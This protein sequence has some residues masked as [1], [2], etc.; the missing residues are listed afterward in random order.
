MILTLTS[1]A[2]N[3]LTSGDTVRWTFPGNLNL[4]E[5]AKLSLSS[6]T[7]DFKDKF[8]PEKSIPVKCNLI[9]SDE[10][11][12]DGIIFSIPGR[13]RDIAYHSGVLEKF[14]CDSSRPHTVMFTF[15][16][17]QVSKLAYIHINLLIETC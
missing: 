8:S 14:L 4:P 15:D 10:F 7:I 6:M 11:N 12:P 1:N 9:S 17:L 13:S 3:F 16:G 2:I 5:N